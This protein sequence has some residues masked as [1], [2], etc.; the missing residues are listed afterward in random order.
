MEDISIEKKSTHDA[1]KSR[2]EKERRDSVT[3][4]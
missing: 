3:R 1:R 4:K 2:A